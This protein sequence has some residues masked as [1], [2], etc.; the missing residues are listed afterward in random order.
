MAVPAMADP[1]AD[2]PV[3]TQ[4]RHDRDD[5]WECDRPGFRDD[6]KHDTDRRDDCDRG[7]HDDP[8]RFPRH[9]M[10]HGMFGSS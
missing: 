7:R 10:P 2:G 4:V 6:W 8:W 1:S 5:Q 9:L 3:I